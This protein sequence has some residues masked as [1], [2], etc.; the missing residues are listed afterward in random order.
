MQGADKDK[1]HA[2]LGQK[3]ARKGDQ[4][5]PAK[6]DKTQGQIKNAAQDKSDAKVGNDWPRGQAGQRKRDR[7][8]DKAGV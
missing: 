5:Q 2:G 8:P 1:G 4:R 6:L 3:G 7:P